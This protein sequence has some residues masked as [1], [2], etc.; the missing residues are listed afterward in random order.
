MNMYNP[1]CINICNKACVYIYN[2][3]YLPKNTE[4]RISEAVRPVSG[5]I[6][7]SQNVVYMTN[8]NAH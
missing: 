8:N 4:I 2:T 7:V 3:F 5:V 1:I 6:N